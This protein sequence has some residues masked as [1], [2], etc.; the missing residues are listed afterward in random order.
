MKSVLILGIS[1]FLLQSCGILDLRTKTLK[2]NGATEATKLKGEQLLESVWIKQGYN[3][4]NRHEVYSFRGNDTWKGL[5]GRMGHLWPERESDMNFKYKVGTFDGQIQFLNGAENKVKIGLQNWNYYELKEGQISFKDKSIKENEKRVF[6]I[7]AFQYFSEM[8]DRLRNAPIISYAGENS[9]R[10]Q[11]YD[12]VFCTWGEEKAHIEHDQ[13]VVWI[14]KETGVMDFVQFTIRESYLKP[15]GYKML[16]GAIEFTDLKNI[17]GILVPH[18]QLIYA[19]KLKKNPKRFLHRLL[20]SNFEFDSFDVE[21]LK[22]DKNLKESGDFK[23][24]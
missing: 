11:K 8:I 24:Y 23:N 21:E 5:L 13:Y 22:L 1:L 19:I 15:P 18:K 20:I 14:N 2:K 4:L 9:F 12:L 7:S 3:K 17:D 16:G 6:G 10:G